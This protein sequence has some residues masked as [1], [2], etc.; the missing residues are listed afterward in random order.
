MG[1]KEARQILIDEAPALWL[2]CGVRGYPHGEPKEFQAI[3]VVRRKV[4]SFFESVLTGKTGPPIT[5]FIDGGAAN[6]QRTKSFLRLLEGSATRL[7]RRDEEA[8]SKFGFA[9][10]TPVL[11][12]DK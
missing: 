2:N 10:V 3:P 4:R 8:F 7:V 5:R 1:R 11:L 12:F 6:E 9:R